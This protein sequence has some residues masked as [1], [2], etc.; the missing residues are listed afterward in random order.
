MAKDTVNQRVAAHTG[1][2]PHGKRRKL[3]TYGRLG[4]GVLLGEVLAIILVPFVG[5]LGSNT[6]TGRES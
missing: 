4:M 1:V 2:E 6:A 5:V 3:V